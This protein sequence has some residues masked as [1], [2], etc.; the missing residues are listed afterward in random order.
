[1]VRVREDVSVSE[2]KKKVVKQ[3]VSLD[4]LPQEV[5]AA[6]RSADGQP[7]EVEIPKD[8]KQGAKLTCS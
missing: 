8:A 7:I 4:D 1:M 5:R 3:E 2:Q 6:V